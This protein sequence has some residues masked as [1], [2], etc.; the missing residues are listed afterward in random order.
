MSAATVAVLLS[1]QWLQQGITRYASSVERGPK[2][3]A[4]R[5]AI[6]L[7]LLTVVG[8]A[9]V[10]ALLAVG[11]GRLVLDASWHRVL[12][13]TAVMGLVSV[14]FG[15]L[16]AVLQ[17]EMRARRYSGY[18]LLSSV[19]RL[20]LAL[21]LVLLVA[22]DAVSLLW[23]Q[24]GAI[25]LVLPWLWRDA[26]FPPLGTVLA[27]WRAS[28]PEVRRMAAYGFPVLGWSLAANVLDVS[29]RWV[30]QLFRGPGEVGVYAANYSLVAGTTGLIAT[31]M[32]LATHPFLMRAW[33]T[34]DRDDVARWLGVIAEW[35]IVAGL[36]LVGV[37]GF[38]ARD[39]AALM[40][41]PEFR[42]G[43]R[44]I[45]VVLAG[46]VVWQLGMYAHKPLEFTERPQLM[47][48]LCVGAA[49]LNVVL[50]LLFVPR[51]GYMAAAYTSLVA[52]G[53]YTLATTVIGRRV[54]RWRVRWGRVFVAVATLGVGLAVAAG[55]RALVEPAY[56]YLAGI[57]ASGV[58]LLGASA[59]VLARELRPLLGAGARRTVAPKLVP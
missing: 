18:V 55:V 22:R 58:V 50:N 8:V 49:A 21:A 12:V 15:P 19:A 10:L 17:A 48:V 40:L 33:S 1:S 28:W 29:D 35:Y 43:W 39:V 31:P 38:Y 30:L 14:P 52:F 53:C 51:Y 16:T 42:T 2:A 46:M 9:G 23:A 4:L 44:I 36:L 24:T 25:A 37:V 5:A 34:G 54:F 45:P 47:F 59:A 20:G 27:R 41:G 32:I 3:D 57:A 7:A 26:R 13:A 11:V 6:A 56:G